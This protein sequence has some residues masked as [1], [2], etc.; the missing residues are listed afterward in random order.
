ML[1]RFTRFFALKPRPHHVRRRPSATA[2]KTLSDF[3]QPLIERVKSG[4]KAL[5][6]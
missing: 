5:A 1:F 2:A 4:M 6:V 3:I